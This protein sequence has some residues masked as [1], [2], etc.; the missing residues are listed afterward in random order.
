MA[1]QITDETL[2]VS[3]E[4]AAAQREHELAEREAAQATAA[5]TGRRGESTDTDGAAGASGMPGGCRPINP[6]R[7][8]RDFSRLQQ[9]ISSTSPPGVDL[10]IS[11][12]I[13]ARKKEGY[14]DDKV[15][16]VTENDRTLKFE[17]YGFEDR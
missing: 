14:P 16:I 2:L 10:E 1:P 7:Y 8:G 3:P 13:T 4:Q 17:S 6:E 5:G 12:E 9:E 15:R 11:V